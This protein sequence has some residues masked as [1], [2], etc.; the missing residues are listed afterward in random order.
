[1]MRR[2]AFEDVGRR[3]GGGL[4]ERD[5]H[6]KPGVAHQ[7][8]QVGGDLA[9]GGPAPDDDYP[10]GRAGL[11]S[12]KTLPDAFEV[13]ARLYGE[14]AVR[15]E[16]LASDAEGDGVVPDGPAV[17][18][19][20]GPVPM[21]HLKDATLREA[22]PAPF[23]EVADADAVLAGFVRAGEHARRHAGVVEV[24]RRVDE[25]HVEAAPGE[26]CHA[27]QR[28]EVRVAAAGQDYRGSERLC[29]H[30]HRYIP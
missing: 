10:R 29:A 27:P 24:L 21:L 14:R 2:E 28:V 20:Q 19:E 23:D 7:P 26:F 6:P 3:S 9:A 15:A 18:E 5:L 12:H 22:S 11:C 25:A 1:M 30:A 13:G 17:L 4:D 16:R 8:G